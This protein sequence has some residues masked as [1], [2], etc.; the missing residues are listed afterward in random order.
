MICIRLA[1]FH[2]RRRESCMIRFFCRDMCVAENTLRGVRV[3][4]S[5]VNGHPRC[6]TQK[7][8]R[9]SGDAAFFG[10]F[11]AALF[12]AHDETCH[13]CSYFVMPDK[14]LCLERGAF[15]RYHIYIVHGRRFPRR[16]KRKAYPR[17]TRAYTPDGV[18][19][20][21]RRSVSA[22]RRK[23][24][25]AH[26]FFLFPCKPASLGFARRAGGVKKFAPFRFRRSGAKQ[27]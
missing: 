2:I 1:E 8:S 17:L 10:S 26:S 27:F 3:G 20:S 9:K 24:H 18:R 15:L 23:L 11:I 14:Q 25:Y 19:R 5:A 7:L 4:S 21:S 13:K 12:C 6:R 22:F 16:S